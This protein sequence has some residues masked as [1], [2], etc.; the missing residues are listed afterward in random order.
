[1]RIRAA[2]ALLLALAGAARAEVVE[3]VLGPL[4]L[5]GRALAMEGPHAKTEFRF[6]RPGFVTAFSASVLDASGAARDHDGLHCH[7]SFSDP[8]G[9]GPARTRFMPQGLIAEDARIVL[10]EGLGEVRFPDGFGVPVS[11]GKSYALEAMLEDED[12]DQNGVYTV[13]YRVEVAPSTAPLK[14]LTGLM[15][16]IRRGEP[17]Q[18]ACDNAVWPVPPGR[19]AFEKPFRMPYDARI[20]LVAT[21][22]HRHL[23]E[24]SILD[25]ATG[26][27]LYRSTAQPG[28]RGYP[29]Q[30]PVYSSAE[31]IP[32]KKGGRYLFRIV[33]DNPTK[34]SS[35]GAGGMRLYV[36]PS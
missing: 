20:H 33:Y 16:L 23:A 6:E 29:R 18:H 19:H 9:V 10:N 8:A 26:K 35:L 22:A 34:A 15:V 3:R 1:M 5:E 21:H 13:R 30:V 28:P 2:A 36:R 27:A 32:V 12:G 31:G 25:V 4:T 7:S 11:T 17:G 24:L 14:A